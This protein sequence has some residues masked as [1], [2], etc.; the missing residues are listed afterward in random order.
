M[1]ERDYVLSE[2]RER[3]P[4]MARRVGLRRI[5]LFGSYTSGQATESSDIGLIIELSAPSFDRY[6]DLKFYLEETLSRPVDLAMSETLKP[7]LKPCIE[8]EV[9]YA[10]GLSAPPG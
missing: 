7:R 6:M 2:L 10:W 5:G 1:L 8:A 3:L 4:D 9:Q